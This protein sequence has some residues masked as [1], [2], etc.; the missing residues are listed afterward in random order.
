[1][2]IISPDRPSTEKQIDYIHLMIYTTLDKELVAGYLRR[3]KKQFVFNL[4]IS[5][6]SDLIRILLATPTKYTFI[7][8]EV[9]E[10]MDRKEANGYSVLGEVEACLHTCPKNIDPNECTHF[11]ER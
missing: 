2:P 11:K 1:M 4:T 3:K 8:G 10:E 9:E 7:C 5:E 6:A